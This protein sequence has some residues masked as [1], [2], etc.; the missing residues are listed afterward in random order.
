MGGGMGGSF[1]NTR[2]KQ[3]SIKYWG[4]NPAKSLEKG[5]EW[6]GKSSLGGDKE[7][8]YNP[9]GEKNGIC[10]KSYWILRNANILYDYTIISGR[11]SYKNYMRQRHIP[12]QQQSLPETINTAVK[13]RILTLCKEYNLSVG[14][15]ARKCVLSPA[16][17][18]NLFEYAVPPWIQSSEFA[19]DWMFRQ[20]VFLTKN[21]KMTSVI[22]K[23]HKAVKISQHLMPACNG[24]RIKR[25]RTRSAADKHMS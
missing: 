6:R 23:S 10:K 8:W 11:I 21:L 24:A 13:K 12:K 4:N 16:A 19:T 9:K 5:F 18:Y 22:S 2:G 17:L 3:P 20:P 14:M 25:F 1:G 7:N 15:L